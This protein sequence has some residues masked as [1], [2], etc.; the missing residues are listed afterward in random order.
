[1]TLQSSQVLS[2]LLCHFQVEVEAKSLEI[3]ATRSFLPGVGGHTMGGRSCSLGSKTL[4]LPGAHFSLAVIPIV[5]WASNLQDPDPSLH[6]T[7]LSSSGNS[8]TP[9]FY[10]F[11]PH[12]AL[13][14]LSPGPFI[15]SLWDW[16]PNG[17][18]LISR[19]FR[20]VKYKSLTPRGVEW[21]KGRG[22][23]PL[24]SEWSSDLNFKQPNKLVSVVYSN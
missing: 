23:V 22:W 14:K 16:P 20:A 3:Q 10:S 1:M 6:W 24:I 2:W 17:T 21:Q 15:S 8:H 19:I 13:R 7:G 11:F 9:E 18:V 12:M 5:L 4:R